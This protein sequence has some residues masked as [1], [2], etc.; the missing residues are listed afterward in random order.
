MPDV[1]VL[2]GGTIYQVTPLTDKAQSWINDNV[3]PDA[4]WL[5]RSLIVE[6]RYIDDI[7]EGMAKDGLNV[8]LP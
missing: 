3:D 8:S 1:L 4:S 7:L 6:H 2:G 5:G